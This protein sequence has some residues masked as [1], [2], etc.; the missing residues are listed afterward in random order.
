MPCR[1]PDVVATL[2]A[3]LPH[4]PYAMALRPEKFK[5]SM[6]QT[7]LF[8]LSTVVIASLIGAKGLGYDALVALQDA[9]RG[10]G[11]LARDQDARVV[12]ADIDTG[13]LERAQALVEETGLS[14]TLSL[15]SVEPGPQV[16]HGAEK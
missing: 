4:P 15:E 9:A 3:I 6:T 2:A 7:I 8:C 14:A 13:V 1:P 16:L 10:R 12:G 5:Q 11:M